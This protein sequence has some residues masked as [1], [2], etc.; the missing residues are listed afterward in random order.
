MY[1]TSYTSL[2]LEGLLRLDLEV[3]HVVRRVVPVRASR[4]LDVAVRV[5]PRSA[6]GAVE[7]VGGGAGGAGGPV[8]PGD[9]VLQHGLDVLH[10]LAHGRPRR[11]RLV[12]AQHR[13]LHEPPE[14]GGARVVP[15]RRVQE[16]PQPV[17]VAVVGVDGQLDLAHDVLA[18]LDRLPP[19]HQLQHHHP[20]AVHVALL[21]Q[22][23]R[24]V[25]LRI[26][27]TLHKYTTCLVKFIF[28]DNFDRSGSC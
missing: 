25:V 22:L 3:R 7:V 5:R 14:P 23:L 15:D 20:E 6:A 10:H 27:V 26:Q 28:D 19:A 12:H 17:V 4:D 13:Q 2:K 18:A 21:R 1:L 8:G 24:H 9:L 11:R 16:A